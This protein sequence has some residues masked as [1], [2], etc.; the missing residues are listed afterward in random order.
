MAKMRLLSP[1]E[2]A[3][4]TGISIPYVYVLERNGVIESVDEHKHLY[5]EGTVT[6]VLE[7]MARP[8]SGRLRDHLG[9][10]EPEIEY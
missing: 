2:L 8:R 3:D 7:Y 10:F 9:R 4:K 5:T 1:K 6:D